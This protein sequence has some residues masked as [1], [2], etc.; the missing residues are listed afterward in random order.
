LKDYA[1][2]KEIGAGAASVVYHAFCRKS[3]MPVALK[4]YKKRKLGV[5]NL[6]Q[7]EREIQ[8]HIQIQHSHI[9]DLVCTFGLCCCYPCPV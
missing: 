9:I 4:I 8:I 3:A 5:L 2:V 6:R 7:V 1:L